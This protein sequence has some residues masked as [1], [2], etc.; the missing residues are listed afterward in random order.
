MVQG[1]MSAAHP[2]HPTPPHRPRPASVSEL[3]FAFSWLAMQG[4]G[5]VLAIVQR[6]VV[7]NKQ[8]LSTQEFVEDWAVAQI[9]PGPNVVNIA[10]MIGDR[11]FGWRGALAALTGML[12]LPLVVVLGLAV[13]LSGVSDAPAG[14]GALKGMGAVSA[15]LIAGTGLKLISALKSNPMGPWVCFILALLTLVAIAG[16]R[17]PLAWVLIGMGVPAFIWAYRT[18]SNQDSLDSGTK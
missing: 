4:F 11:F 14:Q 7:E 15:G 9:M 18:L 13:A 12:A 1:C 3:F 16:L 5:G 8:W 2:A 6:E 10:L 17:M